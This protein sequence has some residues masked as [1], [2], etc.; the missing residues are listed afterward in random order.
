MALPGGSGV[1]YAGVL[2]D[3]NDLGVERYDVNE[4]IVAVSPDGK[5]ALSATGIY[6]VATG[7]RLGALPVTAAALAITPDSRKAFVF[8]G[9]TLIAVD[10][11][12]F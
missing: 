1:Y 6:D 5:R 4:P 9:R 3:G 11:A 10:L 2:L 12:A 7:L 8:T